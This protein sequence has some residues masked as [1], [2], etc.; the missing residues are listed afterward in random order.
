MLLNKFACA[1]CGSVLK[2]PAG[3]KVGASILCPKCKKR[4]A[5]SEP[6]EPDEPEAEQEQEERSSAARA[7]RKLAPRD[8]EVDPEQE[9]EQQEED[10]EQEEEGE[11]PA[12]KPG[13]KK[14]TRK[15]EGKGGSNTKVL[16][17]GGAAALLLVGI[18][19]GLYFWLRTPTTDKGPGPGRTAQ[20]SGEG[21]SSGQGSVPAT[22]RFSL[23]TGIKKDDGKPTGTTGIS[24][25]PD[26]KLA[27]AMA[28]VNQ[29]SAGNVQVWDL[30]NRKKLYQYDNPI[31]SV[32]PVAISPDSKLG[33]YATQFPAR[34]V[35]LDLTNGK[36]V[37]QLRKKDNT[38]LN[39]YT[40]G[41]SFSPKGDLLVVASANEIIGWDPATG[42]E[43]FVWKEIDNVS[44]MSGFYDDGKKIAVATNKGSVKIWDVAT[45][46]P[47]QTLIQG[48]EKISKLF[49]SGDGKKLGVW[50]SLGPVK[51]WDLTAGKFVNEFRGNEG[52][53][54]SVCFLPD[55]R[56]LV[57][58]GNSFLVL[59]DTVTGEMKTF[60]DSPE[61]RHYP[62][63]VT[64]DGSTLLSG[65]ET[66][67]IRVWD[68]KLAR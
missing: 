63:A 49:V 64:P 4:F 11:K 68:L 65:H 31:G 1:H 57:Y 47:V 25:S 46:Q 45:G 26:G 8:E 52:I 48:G 20:Q 13:K 34:I 35:L 30:E 59:Q 53:W 7:K 23:D 60:A 18:G 5:V 29:A 24:V 44:A 54:F 16:A 28:S 55:N 3:V 32:L 58:N 33:A 67:K 22:E 10:Q 56:T 12:A 50:I 51:I 37:R 15:G 17:I 61:T 14:Q 9:P 6:D 43:R 66:G 27:L 19:L 62:V 2:S 38:E 42:V 39:L 40:L 41:L 36:E 21:P